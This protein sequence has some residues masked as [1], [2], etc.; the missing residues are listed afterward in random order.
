MENKKNVEEIKFQSTSRKG[1][2]TF[3][4]IIGFLVK[5][6]K[7]YP[8]IFPVDESGDDKAGG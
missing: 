4:E 1:K 8:V 6:N 5:I 7:L 3:E 2:S